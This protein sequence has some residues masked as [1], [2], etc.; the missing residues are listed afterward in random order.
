MCPLFFW[1]GGKVFCAQGGFGSCNVS[2]WVRVSSGGGCPRPQ[3]KQGLG[4]GLGV[5]TPAP[6]DG[7]VPPC[8]GV[9]VSQ[10][11]L[12]WVM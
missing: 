2:S 6:E 1:G 11:G 12:T 8:W 7:H 9:Q 10:V 4:L 5:L 3:E